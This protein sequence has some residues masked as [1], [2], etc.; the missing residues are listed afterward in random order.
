MSN[1]WYLYREENQYGPYS[2][3]QMIEMLN[4][5]QLF[6][7]DMFYN[8][9]YSPNKISLEQAKGYLFS[10]PMQQN[11]AQN[12]YVKPQ[13]V[14][15][16]RGCLGCLSVLLIICLVF[17]SVV[18]YIS[19]PRSSNLKLSKTQTVASANIDTTGG[20]V[21]VNNVGSS[22]NGMTINVPGGAYDKK[23]NF[24]VSTTA[25]D[26]NKF[27]DKFTPVTPLISVD[28]GHKF[29]NEPMTVSIPINISKDEFAMAFY[30]DK[31]YG[32][33]EGIPIVSLSENQ[34]TVETCHFSDLVVSKIQK[35]ELDDISI[36][37]GFEPGY[38]DWQFV[39]N[40]SNL[41]PNGHC[42]GQ[43]ISSMWYFYE[44]YKKAGERR[45]Y[46]RYDNN[47]YGMGTI[48]FDIDDSWSYRY[49]SVVQNKLNWDSNSKK[50]FNS[51][52]G[53]FDYLTY[54]AFA[55]SMLLTNSP[56]YSGICHYDSDGNMAGGH[57]VVAYKIEKNIIYIADPNYPGDATRK[58]AYDAASGKF[59][60]YQ[61]GA[62]AEEIKKGNSTAYTDIGYFA[63]SSLIN[64]S[65]VGEEYDKM[66]KGESGNG[67]FPKFDLYILKKVDKDTGDE[68]YEKCDSTINITEAETAKIS[69]ALQGK[70]KF[71][72]VGQYSNQ[73]SDL[74][75]ETNKIDGPNAPNGK[76]EYYYTVPLD[77]GVNNLGF[78][79]EVFSDNEYQ[80]VDF[81]RV[82]VTYE[83]I[84]LSGNYS[85]K[86][87]IRDGGKLF[88]FLTDIIGQ[89]IYGIGATNTL[90]E[91][92]GM[93]RD[94][95][96]SDVIGKDIPF[97]VTLTAPDPKNL[98]KYD[99]VMTYQVEGGDTQEY[100]TTANV[101]DGKLE[102][103]LWDASSASSMKFSGDIIGDKKVSGTFAAKLWGFLAN[104][105][106]G[107]F[108]FERVQGS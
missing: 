83:Q 62:N 45:L 30:Y 65:V 90:D 44:K 102:F 24:K 97:T 42:A 31:G 82:R 4:S 79:S 76:G 98:M 88:E 54:Y 69:P 71:K 103:T 25:I 40:G 93:A 17:G 73:Y 19:I 36:D 53:A 14:K 104:A 13:K 67:L 33:L 21:T 101:K 100:K 50:I 78:Y 51:I 58:I 9:E 55:Y 32:T 56:Q 99:M 70:L 63:V 46:G 85:G 84:D 108:E 49:A 26:S 105:I 15:K 35:G 39:N 74:Y 61:S 92:K 81:Q 6:T 96:E 57:A 107:D 8:G 3:N 12:P 1:S 2:S 68:T 106:S 34:I 59:V 91:A 64:W 27:G 89:F 66:T 60:P 52:R 5:Q 37:T 77:K 87:V 10:P 75:N 86:Y 47:D 72:V 18:W 22:I 80:Y 16:K 41:E 7:N 94:S 29:A 95:I 38:D 20:V 11:I 48:D 43:S 28:N 23:M